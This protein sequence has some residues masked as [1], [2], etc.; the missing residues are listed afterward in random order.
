MQAEQ[1]E[2]GTSTIEK[3]LKITFTSDPRRSRYPLPDIPEGWPKDRPYPLP[4]VTV[5][6]DM[7]RDWITHRIIR[8]GVTP[9]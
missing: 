6:P 7:A 3:L 4:P 8:K 1:A 9:N 2:Q 5:T